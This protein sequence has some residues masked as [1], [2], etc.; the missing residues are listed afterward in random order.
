LKT[1]AEPG[2]V[3]PIHPSRFGRFPIT[4]VFGRANTTGFGAVESGSYEG[5][6]QR[7]FGR[8]LVAGHL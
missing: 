3:Y 8:G 1:V 7:V 2:W 5:G 6:F 4:P